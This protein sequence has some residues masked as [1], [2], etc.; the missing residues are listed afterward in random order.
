MRL[1]TGQRVTLRRRV[2]SAFLPV[3]RT[4][5]SREG[6]RGERDT[7]ADWGEREGERERVS[8]RPRE[9]PRERETGANQ[10]NR[11]ELGRSGLSVKCPAVL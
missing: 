11:D 7:Q 3:V 4:S 9:R 2:A 8:E 10:N 6:E 1:A 5:R